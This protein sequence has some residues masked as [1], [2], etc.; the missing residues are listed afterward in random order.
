MRQP[1][2]LKTEEPLVWSTGK[3]KDVWELF[4]ACVAGDLAE[5]T[6]L[7]AHN[8][9]LVRASHAYRTPLYF[10]VRENRREVVALL[11]EHGAD[12]LSLAVND[13]LLDICHDRGYAGLGAFL[14][15][16]IAQVQGASPSGEAVAK[17]I[18]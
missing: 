16:K 7:I 5:V 10:A 15:A 9:A 17:A 18:R 6:R 8:P 4:C 1:D 2:E 12:P 11:L 14:E 3:G 13:S